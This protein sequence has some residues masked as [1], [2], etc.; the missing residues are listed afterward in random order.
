MAM[1]RALHATRQGRGL[2]ADDRSARGRRCDPGCPA[3]GLSLASAAEGLSA[4]LGPP[5]LPG[6]PHEELGGEGAR[7][8]VARRQGPRPGCLSGA[9]A[10]HRPRSRRPA[11]GLRGGAAE[12]RGVLQR[13]LRSLPLT[14][15]CRSPTAGRPGRRISSNACSSRSDDGSR[16]SPTPSARKPCSCSPP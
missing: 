6:S 11:C 14:C 13:R 7:G 8:F 4:A 15:V 1:D 5:A 16:S 12:R 10:R 3:R 2:A 9:V